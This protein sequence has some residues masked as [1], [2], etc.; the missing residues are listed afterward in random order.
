ML[1]FALFVTIL[2]TFNK[3]TISVKKLSVQVLY[4][5]LC[6][7]SIKFVQE[8]LYPVWA[9]LAPYVDIYFVPFGKSAS[10]QDGVSFTCQHGPKECL[11]NK[12]QSCALNGLADQNAQVEYVNCFMSIF[13]KNVDNNE[14]G[15]NCAEAVGLP[16]NYVK[17]CT[18]SLAGVELQLKAEMI[19]LQ[20]KPK[21]VPTILFN[22]H[23]HQEAQDDSQV[24]FR[25]VVCTFIEQLNPGAC[26]ATAPQTVLYI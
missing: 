7:D 23:F 9:E 22:G 11:G 17:S 21:F 12:I 4:E 3:E 10:L 15:Q 26:K 6:P 13:K 16:W 5:S 18:E 24:N 8:Q 19:T 20:Y 1:K 14:M 25:G 2:L